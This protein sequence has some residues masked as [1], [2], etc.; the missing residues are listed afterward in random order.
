MGSRS[1]GIGKYYFSRPSSP[2]ARRQRRE[3]T[4]NIDHFALEEHEVENE[5]LTPQ[6]AQTTSC[7]SRPEPT[8]LTLQETTETS[9]GESQVST[10][11]PPTAGSN[12]VQHKNDMYVKHNLPAILDGD[13]F[14]VDTVSENGEK[15][16][17]VCTACSGKKIVNGSRTSTGNF[18]SHINVSRSTVMAE[19]N[20]LIDRCFYWPSLWLT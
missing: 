14:V 18:A 13:L 12:N 17:A 15:I 1:Q 2:R 8:L 19:P 3:E 11:V 6:Q 20:S 9:I 4:E 5:G 7:R 16:T 10:S